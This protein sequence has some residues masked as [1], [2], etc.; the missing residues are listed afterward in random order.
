M[1]SWL[2]CQSFLSYTEVYIIIYQSSL[3][4][5]YKSTSSFKD[6]LFVQ[7]FELVVLSKFSFYTEVFI[8]F[9]KVLFI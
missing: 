9:I 5:K 4:I 6:I 7:K 8:I 3:Y 2:F 1:L